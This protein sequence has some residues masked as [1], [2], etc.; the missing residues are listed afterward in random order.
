MQEPPYAACDSLGGAR[1]AGAKN[2]VCLCVVHGAF[3]GARGG[4]AR[5]LSCC[6]RLDQ[7]ISAVVAAGAAA[8][9]AAAAA[10]AAGT[11]AAVA[12]CPVTPHQH[13]R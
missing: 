3:E 11:A 9:A 8:A 2:K 12:L 1:V 13:H 4:V 6:S 5:S 7:L 10:R